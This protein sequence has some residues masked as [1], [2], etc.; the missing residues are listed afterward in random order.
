MQFFGKS[1][2]NARNHR[3]IKLTATNKRRS[4][5]VSE[6]NY[7]T[8]K[9]FSENLLAINMKKIKVKINKSVYLVY[10]YLERKKT[11]MYAFWYNYSKPK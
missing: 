9:C 10:Q 11:L 8:K 4:Y 1:M 6:P 3:Y 5:L 2:E 7:H